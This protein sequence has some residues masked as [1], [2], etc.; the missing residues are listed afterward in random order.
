MNWPQPL[1]SSTRID[2]ILYFCFINPLTTRYMKPIKFVF[3]FTRCVLVAVALVGCSST[4]NLVEDFRHSTCDDPSRIVTRASTGSFKSDEQIIHRTLK[5]TKEDNNLYCEAKNYAVGCGYGDI[6]LQCSHNSDEVNVNVNVSARESSDGISSS[7]LCTINLY[8]TISGVEQDKFKFS[9]PQFVTT[10]I[11]MQGHKSVMIDID[12][13]ETV[14]DD[15]LVFPL[16]LHEYYFEKDTYISPLSPDSLKAWREI[17]YGDKDRRIEFKTEKFYH[18]LDGKIYQYAIP[19]DAENL[20]LKAY[21][22]GDGSLVLKV[23]HDGKDTSM[24]NVYDIPF[25]MYN[26][27]K[28]DFH[29][30]VYS[31]QRNRE[32]GNEET[33]CDFEGDFNLKDRNVVRF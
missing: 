16:S 2:I 4:D 3:Q 1:K 22:D 25:V 29:L 18:Y 30:K 9:M 31:V 32:T 14:F 27:T 12:T 6:D 15:D 20:E 23:I 28:N 5:I 24:L 33:T 10:D 26:L 11:D 17:N 7:C 8:F 21:V 19:S 13:K